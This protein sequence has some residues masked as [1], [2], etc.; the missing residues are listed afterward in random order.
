MKTGF[1]LVAV[2]FFSGCAAAPRAVVPPAAV[3]DPADAQELEEA[4]AELQQAKSERVVSR[5]GSN[6]QGVCRASELICRASER[7]CG[8]AGRHPGDPKYTE[9][10]RGAEA[11]CRDVQA[12]CDRC[13]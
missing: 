12:E 7:I 1:V 4:L 13:Q 8:I 5:A 10:C 11:D 9:R 2:L 6:C 3:D